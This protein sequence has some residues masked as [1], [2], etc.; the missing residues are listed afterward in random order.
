[1]KISEVTLTAMRE[2][3][4]AETESDDEFLT[5]VMAAARSMIQNYTGLSESELDNYEDL[6]IAYKIICSDMYDVR[7]LT[8]ASDKMN[9]TVNIILNMHSKNLV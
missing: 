5:A 6:T 7:S 3:L 8:V 1:M 9:P 2:Y 4:R